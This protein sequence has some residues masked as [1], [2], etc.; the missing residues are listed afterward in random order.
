V[1]RAAEDLYVTQS[2]L[3]QQIRRLEDELGVALLR[4]T[5]RG[6]ELTPAGA[7]LLA[8]AEPIL[9][10]AA[11]ARAAMDEHAGAVRGVARVASAPGD[12]VALPAALAAFHRE[13]PGIQLALRHAPAG[14]VAGLVAR[15][16]VDV[17]VA[18]LPQGDVP[19]GIAV[20]PLPPEPLR[21]I[22]GGEDP[23]A[24]HA[25]VA[26]ADLRGAALVLP[27]AGSALR[28]TVLALCAAAGFS[29]V[30]RFEVGDPATVRFLVHAGLAA[31]VVPASWLQ[32]PGPEVAV[33]ELAADGA[34][35]RPALL[36]HAGGPAPAGRLLA[37]A[38]GVALGSERGGELALEAAPRARADEAQDGRAVAEQ[39]ERRR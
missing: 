37:D 2:A 33:A 3:S 29:P 16:S 13:H 32:V 24:A 23:L 39:D 35:H 28:E 7:D 11:L 22:A 31:A 5:P 1:T 34:L 12:A 9:D 36:V 6:V 26:P 20:T 4:R 15:G 38:L 8:R 19:T 10:A 27:E 18:A 25:A 14:E 21:V 30:P 17:G